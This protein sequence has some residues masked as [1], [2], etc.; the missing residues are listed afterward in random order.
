MQSRVVAAELAL[1]CPL[2]GHTPGSAQL[3]RECNSGRCG[4]PL[5]LQHFLTH[6]GTFPPG[7]KRP[8]QC[9][10][11]K[12]W[13]DGDPVV[14]AGTRRNVAAAP[15]IPRLADAHLRIYNA[16]V[17]LWDSHL[18]GECSHWCNPGGYHLWLFLLND[19][20]RD[21]KLGSLAFCP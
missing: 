20:L 12:S 1:V 8:M 5:L 19:L 4:L 10:P 6:E 7:G 2:S 11:L 15:L 18:P 13:Y 21:S 9:R 14:A 17:P 16:T 3:Q